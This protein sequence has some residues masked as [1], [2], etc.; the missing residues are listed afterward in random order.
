VTTVVVVAFVL[1]LWKELKLVSFDPGLATAVGI[2]PAIV[3]YLLMFL[4]ASFTVVAF[5]AVGSILVVAM[6]VVPS[7]TA[8]MLTDRL[9]VMA[10]LSV[11]VGVTSSV[12]GR[13]LASVYETSVAGMMAVA[14]GGLL[15]LA[16]LFSPRH[17]YVARRWLQTRTAI[18]V[19][20]E[21]TLAVLYRLHEQNPNSRISGTRLRDAIGSGW[22]QR[23]AFFWAGRLGYLSGGAG[24]VTL[25]SR[26]IEV[27]SSLVHRHRLWESWLAKHT[28]LEDDHLHA[29]AHRVE[30]FLDEGMTQAVAAASGHPERDP[31]GRPI[32]E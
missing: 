2:R 26:G 5:E 15:V 14:S 10:I 12:L 17:G 24:G 1:L 11:L 25:T 23:V 18:R 27:G 3:H 30:H 4:V 13:E 22:V 32:R 29:A 31:H 6:L 9:E 16:V 28:R 20:L 19:A 8:L 7:A 21:D